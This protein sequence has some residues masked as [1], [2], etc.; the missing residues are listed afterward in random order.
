MRNLVVSLVA[1]LLI[2]Y[3]EPSQTKQEIT[4]FIDVEIKA[5]PLKLELADNSLLRNLGLMHRQNLCNDCGMLFLYPSARELNFWMKNTYIPLDI[6]FVDSEFTIVSIKK[7]FPHEL[8]LVS[9]DQKVQ[10][11][12]EMNQGWF[13]ANG[14][15]AGEK[16]KLGQVVN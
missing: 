8:N 15:K 1:L 13:A 10:F 5:H 6:A 3:S 7:L 2:F 16:I 11:A 12:I 9:S 4:R 14:I